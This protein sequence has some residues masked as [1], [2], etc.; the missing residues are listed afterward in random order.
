MKAPGGFRFS[1]WG[2]FYF[3]PEKQEILPFVKKFHMK[4]KGECP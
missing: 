3:V 4:K 1:L 2:L